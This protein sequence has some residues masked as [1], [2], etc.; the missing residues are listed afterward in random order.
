MAHHPPIVVASAL[1]LLVC[2]LAAAQEEG[3]V[4]PPPQAQPEGLQI[5][6]LLSG[7][8]VYQ[9]EA[10][11]NDGG[12]FSVGRFYI[13]PGVALDFSRDLNLALVVGYSYDAY[14]FSGT[15]GLGSPD[16]WDGINT[17][18]FSARLRWAPDDK[19]TVFAIPTFR[20]AAESGADWDDA[21]QGGVIA[22]FS[23]K[24]NDKLTI[25]PGFGVLT[26]I[27]DDP[28]IFPVLLIDWQITDRLALRTGR[29][30]GATQGPGLQL[31]WEFED[32]WELVFGGRYERLRFRLDNSGIAPGGV[33]EEESI[34]LYLGV[35][36]NFDRFTSVSFLA[37]VNLAGKLTLE[38]SSGGRISR[39]DYD[40]APFLGIIG[41]VRF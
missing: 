38:N 15:T 16:P 25:G 40:P 6:P 7:G 22:G 29:G 5:S 24:I 2:V 1:P 18:R 35:S 8:A 4:P 9:F 37:G 20:F 19:W 21:I 30:L 39:R 41:R 13:E 14:D 12:D 27:E 26:Q 17:L 28:S 11:V 23:Y 10:S 3:T 32:Q 33:G 31:A 34:P 36:Y